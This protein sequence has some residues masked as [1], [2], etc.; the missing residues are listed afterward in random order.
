MGS[1][2]DISLPFVKGFSVLQFTDFTLDVSLPFVKGFSVLQ[3]TGSTLDISLP[4]V[5]KH[6]LKANIRE[7]IAVIPADTLVRVVANTSGG[8]HLPDL[9]FKTV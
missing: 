9:I 7:E 4:F 6:D 8:R 2:L 5:V 1:A 3:S